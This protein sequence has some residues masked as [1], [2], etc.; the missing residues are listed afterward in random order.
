[1][2]IQKISIK[3]KWKDREYHVEDNAD[4]SHKDVKMYCNTNQFTELIVCGP[5]PKTHGA[6]G[7][8]KNY[9]LRFDTKLGH[10]I[11]T[12]RRIPCAYVACTSIIDQLW[13]YGI[14]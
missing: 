10:G 2:E 7:L 1:M 11:C 6:R 5:H 14:P 9:H 4:V 12:I 13:I 8:I 3:R